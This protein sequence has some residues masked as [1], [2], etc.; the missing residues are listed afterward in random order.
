MSGVGQQLPTVDPTG[1][2]IVSEE[3]NVPSGEIS[4]TGLAVN[5]PCQVGSIIITP[6]GTNDGV[7]T[8]RDGGAGGSIILVLRTPATISN[9]AAFNKA[10]AVATSLHVTLSTGVKAYVF[11]RTGAIG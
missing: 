1:H 7:A 4:A 2:G 3:T 10:L 8:F 9:G 11:Y 6:D 5:G